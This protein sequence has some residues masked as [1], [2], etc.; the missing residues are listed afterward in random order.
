MRNCS[1]SS[2]FSLFKLD[3]KDVI[4]LTKVEKVM[5]ARNAE[6]MPWWHLRPAFRRA[7]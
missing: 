6:Q 3:I 7:F 5:S 1:V 2:S 4:L